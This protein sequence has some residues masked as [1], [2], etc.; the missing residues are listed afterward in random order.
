MVYERTIYT[1]QLDVVPFPCKRA[2]VLRDV[3]FPFLF[4]LILAFGVFDE[5]LA[6]LGE[7]CSESDPGRLVALV[8]CPG[9][10]TGTG[11]G[12]DTSLGPWLGPGRLGGLSW[13]CRFAL[14]LPLHLHLPLHEPL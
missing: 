8:R 11:T 6:I 5:P 4:I 1:I 13:K 12:T 10:E 7:T 14:P 2:C 3:P 9:G